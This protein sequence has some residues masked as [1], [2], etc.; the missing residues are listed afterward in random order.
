[1]CFSPSI[2]SKIRISLRREKLLKQ[3]NPTVSLLVGNKQEKGKSTQKR[4]PNFLSQ[5]QLHLVEDVA[6]LQ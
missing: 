6:N 5:T 1:M 2:L 3:K 4:S